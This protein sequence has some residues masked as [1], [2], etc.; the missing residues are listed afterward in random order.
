M[1]RSVWPRCSGKGQ[2]IE[3]PCGT[4]RGSGFHAKNVRLEIK[5]PASIEH[6]TRIRVPGQGDAGQP[7]GATVRRARTLRANLGDT[8]ALVAALSG[9][10]TYHF[11]RGDYSKMRQLTDEALLM[12]DRT[13]DPKLRLAA[14]RLSG[15][16]A[17]HRG[18]FLQARSEFETILSLY[19]PDQHRP[20]AI[21]YVHDPKI[22]ALPY[23]AFISWILGSP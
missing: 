17:M 22:S 15:M 23:I 20:L 2:F 18:A 13:A 3:S 9:E 4:C 16:T 6:N 8:G 14:H 7:T 10:F 19:D 1:M 5:I 12:F 11:V 21:H